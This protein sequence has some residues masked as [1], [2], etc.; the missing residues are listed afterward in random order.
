[1]GGDPRKV[2]KDMI[3]FRFDFLNIPYPNLTPH[4]VS[5]YLYPEYE[6]YISDPDDGSI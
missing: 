4:P 6:I 3:C 1:M 5:A 2:L